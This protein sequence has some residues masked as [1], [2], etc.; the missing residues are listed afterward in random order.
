MEGV[1]QCPDDWKG[2]S[3]VRDK[4]GSGVGM[5]V[6][7]GSAALH[8]RCGGGSSPSASASL[9]SSAAPSARPP[10]G[11]AWD[12]FPLAAEP[13]NNLR[14][15]PLDTDPPPDWLAAAAEEALPLLAEAR[16]AI[17]AGD[18]AMRATAAS[19]SVCLIMMVLSCCRMLRLS[20]ACT[21][22]REKRR[23][24]ARDMWITGASRARFD[25]AAA[26]SRS[27]C[28]CTVRMSIARPVDAT[29]LRLPPPRQ[30]RA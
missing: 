1:S 4:D 14:R 6:A 8:C 24:N 22:L 30:Q 29:G 10:T 23:S 21:V 9:S 5:G 3:C 12:R 26:S 28:A 2:A 27:C 16:G 20:L 17:E 7:G 25:R 15:V 18:C 13:A 11:C 19:M